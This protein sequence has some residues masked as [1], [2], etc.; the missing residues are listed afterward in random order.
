MHPLWLKALPFLK[1]DD[2]VPSSLYLQWSNFQL[3]YD[4]FI[5]RPTDVHANIEAETCGA[6]LYHPWQTYTAGHRLMVCSYQLAT[7]NAL[8]A[9]QLHRHRA[10]PAMLQGNMQHRA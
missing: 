6:K 7:T 2:N 9:V 4:P 1:L 8:L 5:R 3:P 10:T